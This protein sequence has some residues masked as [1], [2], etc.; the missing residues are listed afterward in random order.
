M[1]N[2]LNDSSHPRSGLIEKASRKSV[3]ET[4]DE[5]ENLFESKGMKVFARINHAEEAKSVGLAMRPTEVLIFGDPRTGTPLM[6]RYPHLAI[7]LPLKLL[8]REDEAGQVWVAYNDPRYLQKRFFLGETP[9][10][11][12]DRL[13][14]EFLA[15]LR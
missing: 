7:D 13:I 9:F 5:L 11:M 3:G 4:L 6:N 8:C 1:E 15:N 2:I 14:G 12:P 10:E